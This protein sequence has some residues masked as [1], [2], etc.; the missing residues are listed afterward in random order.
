MPNVTP[1]AAHAGLVVFG[2]IRGW[3]NSEFDIDVN[4]EATS[5]KRLRSLSPRILLDVGANIGDWSLA[6]LKYL[7][8][9]TVHAFKIAPAT[10]AKLIANARDVGDRLIVNAF[11]LG[12]ATGELTLYY[13]PE[14]DT[15]SSTVS[16]AMDVARPNHGVTQVEEMKAP[17]TTGDSYM[18]EHGLTHIDFPKIDVEG[19]ASSVLNGFGGAF[20]RNEIDLV[21]FGYGQV[22]LRTRV[23]LEDFCQFFAKY[24]FLIGKLLP[25]GGGFKPFEVSDEDFIGL[26]FIA[27]RADRG[28]LISAIGCPALSLN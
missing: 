2:A 14:S 16:L 13:T 10:A 23:F 15:A 19:A 26:N 17:I 5:M 22:N 28:D 12:D 6:A 11:G 25:E 21:Q 20:E 27:C 8:D 18:A 7:P 24:G 4:G 3:K 9:A 1:L